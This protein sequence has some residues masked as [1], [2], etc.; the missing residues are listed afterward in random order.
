MYYTVS[1]STLAIQPPRGKAM[2]TDPPARIEITNEVS[3]DVIFDFY[4][5]HLKH[6]QVPYLL[7]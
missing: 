2:Q 5:K 3:Q 6:I 1:D 7:A 4:E